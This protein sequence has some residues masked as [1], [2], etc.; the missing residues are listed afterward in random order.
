M[1]HEGSITCRSLV[2]IRSQMI[3]A[4]AVHLIYL[5]MVI[6]LSPLVRFESVNTE[7][8]TTVTTNLV[9]YEKQELSLQNIMKC[10]MAK[11]VIPL[12]VS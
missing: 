9:L 2:S 12:C 6:R 11:F 10:V 5:K 7:Y 3:P 8:F 1:E 4:C